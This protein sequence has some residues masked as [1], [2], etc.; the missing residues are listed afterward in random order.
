MMDKP[1]PKLAKVM[2][3]DE[4]PE[5]L[6]AAIACLPDDVV[7]RWCFVD[8]T[9]PRVNI[10]VFESQAFNEVPMAY[11]IPEILVTLTKTSNSLTATWRYV[12][13]EG[14]PE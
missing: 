10:L 12:D 6:Q 11:E 5:V 14:G 3:S 9:K 8:P 1:R 13:K 7:L 2:V 4:T